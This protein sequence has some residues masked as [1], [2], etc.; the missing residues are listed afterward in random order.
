MLL[1]IPGPD[2][3]A[4][5]DCR[6]LVLRGRHRER[7]SHPATALRLLQRGSEIP[8]TETALAHVGRLHAQSRSEGR[9]KLFNETS[10]RCQISCIIVF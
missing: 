9:G 3:R 5:R 1:E 7:L 6:R 8:A 10:E 2:R 4:R